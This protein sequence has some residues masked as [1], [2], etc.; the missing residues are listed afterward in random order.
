MRVHGAD[1]FA[2]HGVLDDDEAAVAA[3][4]LRPHDP[5]VSGRVDRG[6]VGG[7][8]VGACVVGGL[9]GERVGPIPQSLVFVHVPSGSGNRMRLVSGTDPVLPP[10]PEGAGTVRAVRIAS[11]TGW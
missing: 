9:A 8:I 2:L 6:A 7:G 10:V 1:G 5:P 3:V 11:A 4:E